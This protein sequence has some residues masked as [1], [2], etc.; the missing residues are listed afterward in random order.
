MLHVI[1]VNDPLNRRDRDLLVLPSEN[2]NLLELRD[3]LIPKDINIITSLNG[4]IVPKE[5]MGLWFPKPGDC[6]MFVPEFGDDNNDWNMILKLVV[7]VAAVVVMA[8][9]PYTSPYLSPMI[10]GLIGM[11]ITI[12]GNYLVN[13]LVPLQPP[14]GLLLNPG[15]GGGSGGFGGFTFEPPSFDGVSGMGEG[16]DT[17]RAFSWSPQTTQ[18][19]GGMIPRYYGHN[20]VYGNIIAGSI[21]THPG[22][23]GIEGQRQFFE[24]TP[25]EPGGFAAGTQQLYDAAVAARNTYD[26]AARDREAAS[27]AY[28]N[29]LIAENAW[30]IAS[31]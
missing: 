7:A 5:N 23:S 22:A 15:G 8:Y 14:G 17:S 20:K 21:E 2:K 12:A 19:E 16:Y 1:K 26:E 11:G 29:E 24:G 28:I 4:K 3:E 30:Y 27:A 18:Q 6:I 25:G 13:W 31:P 9:L 10:I